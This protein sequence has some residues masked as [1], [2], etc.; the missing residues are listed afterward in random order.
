MNTLERQD[1]QINDK[2]YDELSKE[3]LLSLMKS[4][5]FGLHIACFDCKIELVTSLICKLEALHHVLRKRILEEGER[6]F[7]TRCVSNVLLSK[8]EIVDRANSLTGNK[9]IWR[10]TPDERMDGHEQRN[11]Y[12]SI[13]S[14]HENLSEFWAEYYKH[15]SASA[16]VPVVEF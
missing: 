7:C 12:G 8:R 1:A 14:R 5:S 16:E 2:N 4:I 6:N 9:V 11:K 10:D 15:D 13:W 3:D